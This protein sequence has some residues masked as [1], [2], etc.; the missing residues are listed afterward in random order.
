MTAWPSVPQAVSRTLLCAVLTAVPLHAQATTAPSAIRQVI[1]GVITYVVRGDGSVLSWGD[2]AAT[3]DPAAPLRVALPG[4]VRQMAVGYD[5]TFALL[6]DGRVLVW[7]MNDRGQFGRGPGSSRTPENPMRSAAPIQVPLPDDVVQIAA[8]GHHALAVRRDGTVMAWGERP[9][10]GFGAREHAMLPVPGLRNVIKVVATEVHDLALTADG[11]VFAWGEN[12]NGQLGQSLETRRN[13]TPQQVPGLE[14]MVDIAGAGTTN[15]GFSGA[16]RADGTVWMWGSDQSA[17][18]GDGVF[19]G[20]NGP[21]PENRETPVQVKG[22]V[23]AKTISSGGG[24][25]FVLLGDGTVR[26]WG[27]DG[28]GQIGVGTSG[29]YQPLPKRP[30]LTSTTAVYATANTTFAV[31]SDGSLWWWGVKLVWGNT[32]SPL[33]RNQRVPL[34]LALP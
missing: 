30:T 32:R 4:S 21:S 34:A 20:N 12:K 29:F 24:H 23:G 17:T 5:A 18:M 13:P 28:W 11:L 27:H 31:R 10:P 33:G 2:E 8:G 3:G 6:D 14:R 15:F 19:W 26:G 7:G 9:N 16:V 1:K 22:V 25:V